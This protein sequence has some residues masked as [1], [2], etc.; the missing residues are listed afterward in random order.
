MDPLKHLFEKPALTGKLS[1][2]LILLAEFDL[3]YV[4]KNTIKGRVIAEHCVSH[5]V[6]ED[7]LD[8][9]FQDE[10]VLNVEEKATWKMYF[11]RASNQYGYGVGVF[12]IAPDGVHIPLSAKLNFV[13]TN[14]VAKYEACIVSL[15]AL[16][17][18][19]VKEME[20]YGDSALVLAQ[21]Q[22]IEKMKEEHLKP[23]QAYL[24]GVCQKFTKIEYTYMLR[25]Q[26]QFTNALATLAS[27]VQIPKNTF[28]RPIK[29][30]R[31]EAPAHERE[32]CVLDDEINDEKPWYYDIHN[33]VEDR[34]YPKGADRKDRRVLRLLATQYILCGGVLCR[35]SYEGVHLRCVDKEA[36]KTY[37]RSS[38]RGVRTT[39]E[40]ANAC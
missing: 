17:A 11:D 40:C 31:R 8:D 39:H 6:G 33:F 21:A 28:V 29:I 36:E 25:S 7:D 24:E 37:Q 4:A 14:N 16:L 32:V 38:S 18:I 34:V 13:A 15:K 35:R 2:W 26:N 23:Y 20:I 22:R 12:L 10:D 9:D 3:T 27:L 5:P 1:R 30:K 19:D